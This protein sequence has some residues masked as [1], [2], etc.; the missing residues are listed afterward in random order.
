MD[1]RKGTVFLAAV[2]SLHSSLGQESLS[3]AFGNKRAL[4]IGIDGVRGDSLAKA[5]TPNIDQLVAEG[6]ASF[7]G[8]AGGL[9]GT[10]TEQP[11]ISGPG[12]STILT[13]VYANKHGVTEN[14]FANSNYTQYPHFFTR[15]RIGSPGAW[16]G[17]I[18]EWGG[19]D[20]NIVNASAGDFS[21]RVVQPSDAAVAEDAV[22]VLSN[23]NP[24]VLFVHFIAPD[25]YGH[26]YGY[27]PHIPE[28]L[29]AIGQTDV[30]LGLVVDAMRS[31]PGYMNGSED[32]LVIVV[33][34]HGGVDLYHGAQRREE[35]EIPLIVSGGEVPKGLRF[36]PGPGQATVP[37]TVCRHLGVPIDPLWEWEEAPFGYEPLP[38]V[39]LQY[40]YSEARGEISLKW[41]AP[42]D[43]EVDHLELSR[44][45]HAAVNLPV[46]ANGYLDVL[47]SS[48]L[49]AGLN[50]LSYRLSSVDRT[51]EV[52]GVPLLLQISFSHIELSED[53]IAYYSFDDT[54]EDTS[55]SVPPK[56]AQVGG[57]PSFLTSDIGKALKFDGIDDFLI[58]SHSDDLSFGSN[59]DF[60]LSFWYK[61]DGNQRYS[62]Y[63]I[64]NKSFLD[65]LAP[66]WGI[67][68]NVRSGDDLAIRVADGVIKVD[69]PDLDLGFN[70]WY[71]V[72]ATFDRDGEMKLHTRNHGVNQVATISM[73]TIGNVDSGHPITV[74]HDNSITRPVFTSMIIDDLAIWG[75]VLSSADIRNI[76]SAGSSGTP[77][78]VILENRD[79][80]NDGLLD[81]WELDHIGDLSGN[82]FDDRDGNG[83]VLLMEY[84]AGFSPNDSH[85]NDDL[86]LVSTDSAGKVRLAS[87]W[88]HDTPMLQYFIEVSEDCVSWRDASLPLVSVNPVN[89]SFSAYVFMAGPI[90]LR[91]FYRLRV[92]SQF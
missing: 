82:A 64:S 50:D 79:R 30:R 20:R 41:R 83:I 75:R 81:T 23:G 26:A 60:S 31:R 1:F 68:A 78:G 77:L 17:S 46:T 39:N 76:F 24:D 59:G 61:I 58:L 12:W 54:L 22:R 80:D 2:L 27:G 74:G 10:V 6:T 47:P 34:D 11:T 45:D 9:V 62:P 19:I 92:M 7:D 63:I 52:I 37:A 91:R 13:G 90:A 66:G 70:Q 51:G 43:G 29:W 85:S 48:L 5:H 89:S 32:W 57:A 40:S 87:V 56:T 71:S 8:N 28:Y 42:E 55:G 33:S 3:G 49:D 53:L 36:S 65:N 18:V 69:A 15:L 84:A 38:A 14:T 44:D 73:A 88:R 86:L 35:K 21:Y 67:N 16:L 72:I 25:G 4:I